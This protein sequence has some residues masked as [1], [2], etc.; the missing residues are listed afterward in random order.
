MESQATDP[1]AEF[2]RM[3][4]VRVILATVTSG[5]A[6]RAVPGGL[7]VGGTLVVLGV[8]ADPFELPT[9]RTDHGAAIAIV[10]WPSGSSSTPKT[11]SPSER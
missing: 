3:G 1:A 7:A 8:A 4:G 5:T 6:M 2:S 9:L 11:R 10:G